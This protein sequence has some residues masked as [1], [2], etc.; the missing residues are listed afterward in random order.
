MNGTANTHTIAGIYFKIK[1]STLGTGA[2]KRDVRMKIFCEA[3]RIDDDQVEVRYL[4]FSGRPSGIKELLKKEDFL[5]DFIYY[6]ST[7]PSESPAQKSIEKHIAVADEHL[8]KKE[9]RERPWD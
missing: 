6:K 8:R 5:K 2:T 9:P 7:Y 4:G 1:V 3:R